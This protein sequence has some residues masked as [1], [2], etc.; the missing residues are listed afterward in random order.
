MSIWKK[1]EDRVV[2]MR[3]IKAC[4]AKVTILSVTPSKED[5]LRNR[6]NLKETITFKI[7]SEIAKNPDL[8]YCALIYSEDST[9]T[10]MTLKKYFSD[11]INFI[12]L[13]AVTSMLSIQ[14]TFELVQRVA[15]NPAYNKWD[16]ICDCS[17]GAKTMAIGM[18]MAYNYLILTEGQSKL[19]LTYIQRKTPEE[20]I[21]FNEIEFLEIIA[22]EQSRYVEQQKHIGRLAYLAKIAPVLAHE[23]KNPLNLL[24]LDLYQLSTKPIGTDGQELI[25][26]MKRAIG[27]INDIVNSVQKTV[28]EDSDIIT[29][30]IRLSEVVYRLQ[31]RVKKKFPDLVFNIIGQLSGIELRI[32]EVKLYSIFTNLIDNTANVTDGKGKVE[33]KFRQND[34]FLHIIVEDNGPGIREK[35]LPYLFK[36]KLQSENISG[37]GIGLMIVRTFVVEA[38]GSITIDNSFNEGCRF[39]IE[40]PIV[41]IEA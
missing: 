31:Q 4:E 9:K 13:P 6:P 38:G 29:P 7:L 28:R 39:L 36:S 23:I 3:T 11:K 24:S 16:I 18:A 33:L 30:P 26:E 27:S 5:S 17:G 40:L 12:E 8:P 34:N 19:I 41:K 37:T 1:I 35:Q 22:T 15:C 25:L 2:E 10:T 32:P 21:E 20:L 14:D